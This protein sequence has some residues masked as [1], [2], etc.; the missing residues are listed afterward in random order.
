MKP[1]ILGSEVYE[2]E[3]LREERYVLEGAF[4]GG[5]LGQFEL[6]TNTE[7]LVQHL[8]NGEVLVTRASSGSAA[9]EEGG[10]VGILA[11]GGDYFEVGEFGVAEV[12]E[13]V[14]GGE[15]TTYRLESTD[16]L[17]DFFIADLT[18][19]GMA[20]GIQNPINPLTMLLPGDK[21]AHGILDNIPGVPE[22]PSAETTTESVNLDGYGDLSLNVGLQDG[23]FIDEIA[24]GGVGLEVGAGYSRTTNQAT[25]E[26]FTTFYD[27]FDLSHA[28]QV[29]SGGEEELFGLD[30]A[31]VDVDRQ[32][33]ATLSG[34]EG[35]DGSSE[36]TLT[37]EHQTGDD[38]YVREIDLDANPEAADAF[39]DLLVDSARTGRPLDP[40]AVEQFANTISNMGDTAHYTVDSDTYGLEVGAGIA[41]GGI[42][43]N[44]ETVEKVD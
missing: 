20:R 18:R 41:D 44:R 9:V 43:F 14:S 5:P 30:E 19:R 38:L 11:H 32:L 17:N 22:L 10:K 4:G 15:A 29:G 31:L 40:S 36:G 24:R 39:R 8:D 26:S 3:V 2:P 27:H 42:V 35:S 34:T 28:L 21:I 1:N 37:F 25:G 6:G 12:G 13:A 7:Y 33:R 16:E 23:L